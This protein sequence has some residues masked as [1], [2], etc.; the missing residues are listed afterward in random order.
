M[1]NNEPISNFAQ[2]QNKR[3]IGPRGPDGGFTRSPFKQKRAMVIESD[4][5]SETPSMGTESPKTPEPLDNTTLKKTTFGRGRPKLIRDRTSPNSPQ[6]PT[7]APMPESS[8]GSLTIITTNT[9]A[10]EVDRA[11]KDAKRADQD[12][13]IRDENGKVFTDSNANSNTLEDN[14]ENSDLDLASNLSSST[15]IEAEEKEP[16][17]RSKKLTKTNPIAKYC[18]PICH[19]YRKHR[20]KTELGVHIDRVNQQLNRRG[21]TTALSRPQI[22]TLRPVTNR[23]KPNCQERLTVHQTLDLW[24]D[25]RYNRKQNAPIGR[26]SANSGRGNVED[27]RTHLKTDKSAF[28]IMFIYLLIKNL[29][30][31]ISADEALY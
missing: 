17:R 19:D 11:I 5:G 10:T 21:T 31:D 16:I 22:Q 4:R 9:T 30:C 24:R 12:V 8:M 14:L 3:G 20:K 18:N 1:I 26:S 6:T 13:F 15:E 29:P 2:E 23:N 7:A 25:D 27:R 28:L